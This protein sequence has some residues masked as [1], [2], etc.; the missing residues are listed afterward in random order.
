MKNWSSEQI[1]KAKI[2]K[3]RCSKEYS[4]WKDDEYNMG[5]LKFIFAVPVHCYEIPSFCSLNKFIVY[6]NRDNGIY[7]ADVDIEKDPKDDSDIYYQLDNILDEFE[8]FISKEYKDLKISK[9]KYIDYLEKIGSDNYWQDESLLNIYY[10]FY[11]FVMS[12]KVIRKNK[13]FN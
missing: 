8:M 3:E 13:W 2:E 7:F 5:P 10:K 12:L 9:E 11:T 1:E 6:Y 4:D